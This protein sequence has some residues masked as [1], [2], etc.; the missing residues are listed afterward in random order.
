[1]G[2][3]TGALGVVK[4]GNKPIGTMKNIRCSETFAR[5][6]VGGLGTIYSQEA[7]V[8]KFSGSM[9]C[10]YALID[11]DAA[12]RIAGVTRTQIGSKE[13]FE[14]RVL[15]SSGL[16]IDVYKKISDGINPADGKLKV[17]QKAA[18]QIRQ[19]FMD[20]EGFDLPEGSVGSHDQSFRYLEPITYT[21]G[22]E[23]V[24]SEANTTDG[25]QNF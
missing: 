2:T 6:E 1:M 10:S 15:F 11:W 24:A 21:G 9:S 7:P 25:S 14:A 17:D 8:L 22:A 18:F 4:V 16:T 23:Y 13:E 19:C 20:S 12:Y 5:A 3:F